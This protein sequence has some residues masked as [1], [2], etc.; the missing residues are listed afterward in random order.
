MYPNDALARAKVDC[1]LHWH[2]HNSRRFT[3]GLFAPILRP[4]MKIS[5]EELAS[6][7]IHLE[8]VSR[9]M[10]ETLSDTDFLCGT[11]ATIADICVYEDVGQCNKNNL[12]IYDFEPYP[13]LRQ[14]FARM[15]ALPKY[16]QTHSVLHKLKKF[17]HKNET[18]KL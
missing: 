11:S 5:T 8:K 4:D 1:W 3:L 17:F 6:T 7:K 9:I 18:A 13:A 10:N 16:E 12:D 15:E 14:W 2:H